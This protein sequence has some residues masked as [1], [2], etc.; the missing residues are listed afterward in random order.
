MGVV[1]AVTARELMTTVRS[2]A[3]LVLLAGVAVVTAGVGIAG[4]GEPDY[5]PTVVDL[6]LPMEFLVPAVAVALGYRTVVADARRG[7]LE[8]I[9]TYPVAAWRYVVGVYLGRALAFVSVVGL[10]LALVG[11]YLAMTSTEPSPVFATHSGVDSPLVFVRFVALTLAFGL[12]VLA[13]TVAASALAGSR[14]SALVFGVV[15]FA[16]VVLAIDLLVVRGFADGIVPEQQLRTVLAASPASAY[17]GLVFEAAISTAVET[18]FQQASP[19]LS[20]AS[21]GLWGV[22]ALVVATLAVGR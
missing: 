19:L 7:E 8:V 1:Q 18:E 14:R 17:R 6:L 12:V 20:V 22:G 16:L 4:G 2:R 5:L 21:L 15:L 11:G 9:R 13:M 10:P 3:T